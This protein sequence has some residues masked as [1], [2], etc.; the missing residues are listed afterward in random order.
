MRRGRLTSIVVGVVLIGAGFVACS[1]DQE[2]CAARVTPTPTPFDALRMPSGPRPPAPAK[3]PV[4]KPPAYKPP[5]YRSTTPPKAWKDYQP[6]HTWGKPYGRGRPVPAQPTVTHWHGDDY[7]IYPDY[8]GYY[9]RGVWPVGYGEK[10]GCK[11]LQEGNPD[12][13]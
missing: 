11:P 12:H 7:R 2:A 8:P 3:P 13:D 10:F 1:D 9:R 4:Y 6:P 5:A